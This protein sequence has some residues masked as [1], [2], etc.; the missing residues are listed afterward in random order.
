MQQKGRAS[1]ITAE[2][3]RVLGSIGFDFDCETTAVA[4]IWTKRVQELR[5]FKAQFGHCLVPKRYPAN[6]TL[7]N[8]VATQRGN[9]K[10]KTEGKLSPMTAER[11]QALDGIGF[12]WEGKLSPTTAERIQHLMLLVSNVRRLLLFGANNQLY[13]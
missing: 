2:R 12:E 10:K 7:G 4:S 13:E 3:I 8:W 9:C 1:F 11:I 5:E 6:P